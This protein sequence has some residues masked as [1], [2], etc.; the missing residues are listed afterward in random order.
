MLQKLTELIPSKRDDPSTDREAKWLHFLRAFRNKHLG[1]CS[2]IG[3]GSS[4]EEQEDMAGYHA[5]A[6]ELSATLLAQVLQGS[7]L[8]QFEKSVWTSKSYWKL[9][10]SST[11]SSVLLKLTDS[12]LVQVHSNYCNIGNPISSYKT[13]E[14]VHPFQKLFLKL[15]LSC[16]PCK[17]II[18]QTCEQIIYCNNW[19]RRVIKNRF[20]IIMVNIFLKVYSSETYFS[21]ACHAICIIW[22]KNMLLFVPDIFIQSKNTLPFA[23]AIFSATEWERKMDLDYIRLPPEDRQTRQPP[24]V[25]QKVQG[26]N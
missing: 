6:S 12:N 19:K 3:C 26:P 17:W 2:K 23:A 13:Q 11:L 25:G 22:K 8:W 15:F 14:F 7:E 1:A 18:I 5:Q 16:Q 24:W 9:L 21:S 4:Q 20:S 10:R